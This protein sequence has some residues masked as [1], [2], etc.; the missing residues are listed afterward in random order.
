MLT[1]EQV[2][3]RFEAAKANKLQWEHHIRECYRYF[4]PERNTMDERNN[5]AKKR[6]WVFDSTAQDS[7]AD[8]AMRMESELIPSN[9]NWMKLESGSDIPED[10][11]ETVNGYLEESTDIVFNHI[12]SSNF[13]SQ[14]H[15]A[16][17]DL[18]ISTG[19]LVVEEG[20][21]IQSALNFRCISLSELVIE[22][23]Q[24]GIVKTVFR[25]F[26]I[27]VGDILEVYPTAKL[28]EKLK[29]LAANKPTEEVTLM[30]GVVWIG[31]TRMYENIVT[32]PENKH[33]LVQETI[34]SSPWVVFRESTIPG[35]T[36]G[37]G[38][39]MTALP[40]TKTL[41]VMVRDYLKSLAWWS[42]PSFTATDDGVINAHTIRLQPGSVHPVGSNDNANPTLRPMDVGGN[43]QIAMD[44]ISRLQDSIRRVMISKPF[45][46]V[47]E[48]PVRT[49][50]EMSMRQADVAKTSLGASSRIQNEL[51]ETLV[52]R[53]VYILKK[54]GKIADFKID[55]K[56][57]KI[58]YTSP[59]A[60]LQDEQTLAAIGRA[61]E[62][63]MAFP[64]ELVQQEIKM[65]EI[66]SEI[67]EILGLPSRFVRSEE[68]K[69][70]M[71]EQAQQ[72]QQQQQAQAVAMAQQEQGGNQ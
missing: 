61:M 39:A 54:A 11:L 59:S 34:E 49:A 19:A 31:K 56:Q 47:E 60:R 37:R 21:G 5:G 2:N 43:P 4:M 57:V 6:E 16:F 70:A 30:E 46:N 66:P 12:R 69:M 33:F 26:K 28:T 62:M 9:I 7:L 71:A 65:E 20:D 38:R 45:G 15:T 1:Y 58:K 8:F 63:L 18:G 14:A 35:E 42:S 68:E 36:Y 27:P 13:A 51:M 3:K 53:C 44:A 32:Y 25:E 29:E 64:P 24:Q 41:N 10:K 67:I 17:L 40:D 55:G 50:T 22:Q 48:T 72:Q 23:S 52:A